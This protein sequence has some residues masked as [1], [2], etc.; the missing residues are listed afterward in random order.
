MAVVSLMALGSFASAQLKPVQEWEYARLAI[1]RYF[2][3]E[4]TLRGNVPKVSAYLWLYEKSA[5]YFSTDPI[6][7]KDVFF[8]EIF[9]SKY[10]RVTGIDALKHLKSGSRTPIP[11]VPLDL[12][13]DHPYMQDE[14]GKMGWELVSFTEICSLGCID[15]SSAGK[16][17]KTNFYKQESYWYKR[18]RSTNP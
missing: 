1:Y 3:N 12:N 18:I 14:F 17:R 5:M 13:F 11:D 15:L 8:T 4:N 7:L 6:G 16:E 2:E 10:E 9:G